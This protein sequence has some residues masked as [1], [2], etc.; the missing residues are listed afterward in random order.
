MKTG[1]KDTGISSD[2]DVVA[3]RSKEKPLKVVERKDPST[4][5]RGRQVS[6][7]GD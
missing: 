2:S 7:R 5:R 1:K 6:D 3:S 4:E